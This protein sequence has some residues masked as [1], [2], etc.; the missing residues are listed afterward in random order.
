VVLWAVEYDTSRQ[1]E[2]LN[3]YIEK[4]LTRMKD[5]GDQREEG[6]NLVVAVYGLSGACKNPHFREE[7]EIRLLVMEP[8]DPNA[9]RAKFTQGISERFYRE[10]GDDR[11]SYFSLAFPEDAVTS[12]YCGPKND[13]GHD[14]SELKAFLLENGYDLNRVAIRKS[15]IPYR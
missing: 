14:G 13:A 8:R 3:H 4:Y 10:K 5:G 15:D 6:M 7:K 9:W 2:L 1:G 11:I 12:I